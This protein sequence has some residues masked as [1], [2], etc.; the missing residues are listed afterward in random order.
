MKKK[1]KV[2][3]SHR[4][5][6]LISTH[7]IKKTSSFDTN[8]TAHHPIL[9]PVGNK[10]HTTPAFSSY[11]GD[12]ISRI[13]LMVIALLSVL[14]LVCSI[15][16]KSKFL[17]YFGLIY[18]F[19]TVLINIFKI[20][21]FFLSKN[22]LHIKH[23]KEVPIVHKEIKEKPKAE[24]NKQARINSMKRTIALKHGRYETDI[25]SLYLIIEKF[26]SVK[27]SEIAEVFKIDKTKAEQWAKI[28]ES[29]ELVIIHYPA[30]G[31]PEVKWKQ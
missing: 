9:H 3:H 25:D 1:V 23:K 29:H 12:L 8:S 22:L 15:L 17:L 21:K 18:A 4:K 28:L 20:K 31:E 2:S 24:S 11:K 19:I 26:K 14:L 27:F 10:V 16:L 5:K 30:F 7:K 13:F 6:S